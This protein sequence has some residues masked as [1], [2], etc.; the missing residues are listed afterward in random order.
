MNNPNIDRNRN[1]RLQYNGPVP[2][3]GDT[4][5]D[6]NGSSYKFIKMEPDGRGS[7]LKDD[8]YTVHLFIAE[9]PDA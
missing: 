2:N 5:S 9:R 6:A 8:I 3:P 4:F 7:F 1:N